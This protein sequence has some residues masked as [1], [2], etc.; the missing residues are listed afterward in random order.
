MWI[1]RLGERATIF[2]VIRREKI[3]VHDWNAVVAKGR[4][5]FGP[6]VDGEYNDSQ[7]SRLQQSMLAFKML[8]KVNDL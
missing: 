8:W 2:L 7:V 3:L 6:I 1:S 4:L 5:H